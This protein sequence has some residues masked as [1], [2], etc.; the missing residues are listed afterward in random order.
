MTTSSWGSAPTSAR[1]LATA[2]LLLALIGCGDDDDTPAPDA[3][4]T[5][6]A[7]TDASTDAGTDAGTDSAAGDAGDASTSDSL[8]VTT[9][10]GKVHGVASG[11]A[12]AFRGI[13]FAKPP[14]GA[15]RFMPPEPN[16]PWTG[17][18]EVANFREPC[19]QNPGG[20]SAPGPYSED[21]LYLNVY[22]PQPAPSGLPVM[23]WIHGGAFV[24]GGS[25]QYPGEQFVSTGNVVLVSVAYRVGALGFLSHPALDA[26]RSVPSGNDGFRDQLL[27]LQWVKRNVAAFGGDPNNVTIMGES[28]G[29][30]ST[31]LHMASPLSRNLAKRYIMESASCLGGLPVIDKAAA[32]EI[33]MKLEQQLCPNTTDL[34]A[35][36]GGLEATKILEYGANAG[37]SGA[38]WGPVV[39]PADDFLPK[40]PAELIADP[41]FP[42][43]DVLLG[44]NRNEWALFLA[45][46]FG[47]NLTTA[48]NLAAAIDAEQPEVGALIKQQYGLTTDPPTVTDANASATYVRI[49]TDVTF[50]CP[51]RRLA[52]LVAAQGSNVYLY[53][54][55]HQ[56]DAMGSWHAFEIPYVFANPTPFLAPELDQSLLAAFQGYW[57]QFGRTGDPNGG[58]R[59]TWPKYNA[60]SDQHMTL[61]ATP[62]VGSGLSRSDCDFWERPDTRDHI[63]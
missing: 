46:G 32:N 36:L 18:L 26:T 15:R 8:E 10:E 9:A 6:D 13:P 3:S 40:K 19:M 21:C 7:G 61:T 52:R 44:T 37:I 42:K 30:M 55:E 63:P 2:A 60:E 58:T 1:R 11:R 12:R 31:C 5:S 24:S 33:G 4:V 28:A 20:L 27:A 22:T 49:M 14:T 29:S 54:F 16:E 51:T 56:A 50:R 47:P 23:V 62:A 35:C 39:N 17:T 45:F 34:R 48:A 43:P 25:K 57:W 41:L 38:G 53:S 59:P